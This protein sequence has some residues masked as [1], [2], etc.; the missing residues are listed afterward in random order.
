MLIG[1]IFALGV[2][3]LL[4]RLAD[5]SGEPAHLP[6]PIEAVFPLPGDTV[7]RQTAIEIDLPVGY[8]LDLEVDGIEIPEAELGHTEATGVFLWQPGPTATIQTWGGGEHTV[9]I[10]WDRVAGGRPDP[11]EFTWRFRVT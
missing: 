9:T 3:A 8:A 2:V 11:G 5:P 6:D 7:V 4:V 1:S 10:R